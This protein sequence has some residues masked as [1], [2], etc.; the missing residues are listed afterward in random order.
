MAEVKDRFSGRLCS[1]SPVDGVE[2]IIFPHGQNSGAGAISLAAF[3]GA[4]RIVL[5]GYDGQKTK[6][7]AHWHADHPAKLGNA[8][9][10]HKWPEQFSRIVKELNGAEVINASRETAIACFKRESLDVALKTKPSIVINGMH[11]LGDNLHQRSIVKQLMTQYDVW[12]E[13]PWPCL[14]HDLDINLISKGSKLRTQAKNAKREADRFITGYAPALSRKLQVAYAPDLVRKHGSVLAAMSAQCGTKPE[15]F[16]LPIPNEWATRAD[17]LIREWKPS[18]PIM[19]YRPLVERTEWSG[20]KN[21]N[22][23]SRSYAR[24]YRS[25]RDKYFVVSIADIED[26]KEWITSEDVD[27]DRTYHSGELDVELLSALF[28]R[29][30]LVYTS[31]GFA[32]I[33][34]QSVGTPVT[35][36]FGGYENSR[37][38]SAG[39]AFAPYL[40][41]DTIKPC[42]CFSHT[43]RC[44]KTI[45]IRKAMSMLDQ[46][47]ESNK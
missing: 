10:A 16:S 14:Y 31:P 44:V 41:I 37:S 35:C 42:E 22:P 43:H 26:G 2:R 40:G 30:S 25:I 6:G 13:T 34:A 29:S 19:I 27:V 3:F 11:G 36:V 47:T 33:L 5:I 18:K 1:I 46:F 8:G 28:K 24:L 7:K 45:D 21:R 9:V 20:C 12:L 15:D 17:K 38:F 4:K 23:D 32:V 39:A